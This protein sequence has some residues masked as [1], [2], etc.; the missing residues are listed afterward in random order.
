MK[1]SLGEIFYIGK[2]KNLRNRL[3]SYFVGTDTRIF[4]QY[5]EHMLADIEIVVVRN[6]VEALLLE[7]ELIK[8]HQPRFNIM[9]KDDKNYLLLKLKRPK[10]SSKKRA[11]IYPRLEIVRKAKKDGA[12]YFG[13]YPSAKSLRTTL[14][15]INK[16]FMLRVCN[17]QVIANRARPCIQYQIGR[18]PAPCVF[19]VPDYGV[20]VDNAAVFLSG[21]Y[22]EI[23]KR[24][25]AKMWILSEREQ[26][27]AAARVRDQLDAI[28]TSLTKQVITDVNR[29]RNQDI[30]GF[31]RMGPE[32]EIVQVLIRSGQW[33][34]NHNYTFT[35]QPFPSEEILRAFMHQAYGEKMVEDPPHDILLPL[36]I[37]N[38]L[39]GLNEELNL[40]AGHKVHI[41][42]PTKG[43]QKRLVEIAQKNAVV[44]LEERDK[45]HQAAERAVLALQER[46][47]LSV[48]PARIECIDISL[49][50]GKEPYGSLVVFIDGQAD[51][52][53]YRIFKIKTVPGMD[54]FAMIH[55][56]VTR[57]IKKGIVDNDLPDLLLIDG[58][59]GQ[60]SSALK[61]IEEQNVLVGTSQ[62]LY[63][64][65]IAKARTLKGDAPSVENSSERLFIPNES[66][67]IMLAPHTFERYLVERIRDEAHRFA[68]SAHRRARAKRML[69]S[70][71]TSLPG[72]GK[73]RALD[74]L[75][76]FG[77][78]KS[79]R[80][81]TALDIAK[82]IRI[83]EE[84]AQELLLLLSG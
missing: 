28:R 59:K 32:V 60:L 50:Q 37:V 34:K 84:K 65:G 20:E 57:R 30:I 46:L 29:S 67:P 41:V 27:E 72:I 40:R 2:A 70:E 18:C 53:K 12:R 66:E 23:E 11:E 80:Q 9:L 43:K 64:V 44:A 7:R 33:H 24:L 8:K 6:D 15:L 56:V 10:P 83:S 17:D 25:L 35:D 49:I 77:S 79:L 78:V 14:D 47:S 19:E 62:G 61:A 26:F 71:L 54:D 45:L 82:V 52:S 1:D 51:K 36:P 39:T 81:A 42:H 4:V 76:H 13:P 5:L 68:L 75:R 48:K 38:E 74:L 16:Y 73:K 63:V 69:S 31:H 21:N 55:E 58:G 3:R 22:Q